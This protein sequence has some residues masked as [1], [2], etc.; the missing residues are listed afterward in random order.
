MK[1]V[2]LLI[3]ILGLLACNNPRNN[4]QNPNNRS[5]KENKHHTQ[6]V[7]DTLYITLEKLTYP[8]NERTN[9][10]YCIVNSTRHTYTYLADEYS[11]EK[12]EQGRWLPLKIDVG[13]LLMPKTLKPNSKSN[14]QAPV[15][16]RKGQY[17]LCN[18]IYGGIKDTDSRTLVSQTLKIR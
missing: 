2:F 12:L 1:T 17:R 13:S 3:A 15:E 11:I 5:K 18:T 8:P 6:P 14:E 16:L 9:I 10:H 7:Q 4:A